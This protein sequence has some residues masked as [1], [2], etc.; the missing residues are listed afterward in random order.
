MEI[1]GIGPA[2]AAKQ[3]LQ[4]KV[5]ISKEMAQMFRENA[6][7]MR[8]AISDL[9]EEVAVITTREARAKASGPESSYSSSDLRATE[10]HEQ[11]PDEALAE[12]AS[13]LT[14]EEIERKKKKE[15]TKLSEFQQRME[16]LAKNAE[17]LADAL[18]KLPLSDEERREIQ[19]FLSNMN[20]IKQL[21]SKL[22]YIEEK[23]DV[24]LQLLRKKQEKLAQESQAGFESAEESKNE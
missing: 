3:M 22:K 1:Q 16:K 21:Q 20:Q 11:L 6:A 24:Y 8:E 15:K 5:E 19:K 14:E 23:E 4:Q 10:E 12:M 18:D 9:K 13:I 7:N 2:D 17:V